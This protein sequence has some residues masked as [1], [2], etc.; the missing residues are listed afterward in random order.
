MCMELSIPLPFELSDVVVVVV[1]VVSFLAPQLSAAKA[2]VSART[3][4]IAKARIFRIVILLTSSR[5][6]RRR[7]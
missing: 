5:S 7:G 4:T 2:T 1:V 3:A 6:P